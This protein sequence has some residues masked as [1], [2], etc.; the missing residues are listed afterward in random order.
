[1][2]Q[3][4]VVLLDPVFRWLDDGIRDYGLHI[5]M[6]CV[7]LSPFQIACLDSERGLLEEA[8]PP[9]VHRHARSHAT[10]QTCSCGPVGRPTRRLVSEPWRL[11]QSAIAEVKRACNHEGGGGG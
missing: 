10:C 4:P 3:H 11:Q 9:A 1:M 8:T 6:V 5:Y 7:W 2:N